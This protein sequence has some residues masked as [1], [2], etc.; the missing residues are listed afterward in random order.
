MSLVPR[1]AR[2]ADSRSGF[3]L[4][5]LLVVIAI[6]A[7][8]ISLLLPAIQK[9]R[10]ASQ[11]TQ[12][13]SNMRQLGI[14]LHSA[15]DAYTAMPRNGQID[16][17][18]P[19][20]VNN[21]TA[22]SGW[23][24]GSVHFYLL[25]FIDQQNMMII[26][27]NNGWTQSGNS[28]V[29]SYSQ[30]PP[31]IYLCPS[32][33]SGAGADGMVTGTVW[34]NPRVAISNYLMNFQVFGMGA[35]KVPSSFPDGASTTGLIYEGYG[36]TYDFGN[37][38][39]AYYWGRAPWQFQDWGGDRNSPNPYRWG[40]HAMCYWGNRNTV[41]NEASPG[42]G[43]AFSTTSNLWSKFQAQPSIGQTANDAV[44]WRTQSMH[45]PGINVL[46]GDASGKLVAPNVSAN[47]WSASVTP[48]GKD[49]VG[50]DW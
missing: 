18:W 2:R 7:V 42:D 9:V 10:E 21:G 50:T 32:D 44:H 15:Q 17:P 26:W 27:L 19:A 45:A 22:P 11:R 36:K 23:N 41:A 34:D 46:M 47:T 49:V 14:A 6:I 5:E 16:Y 38:N 33:P 35:P 29:W 1:P 48:V 3:T 40:G 43:A 12:C 25:P 39:G 20:G 13:Q 37:P 8:L 28:N 24:G 30:P 4:I 31:K